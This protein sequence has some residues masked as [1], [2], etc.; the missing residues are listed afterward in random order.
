MDYAPRRHKVRQEISHY[1][2]QSVLVIVSLKTVVIDGG[3]K[4]EKHVL[5][6]GNA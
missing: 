5:G 2:A 3:I 4:V 1:L 6:V